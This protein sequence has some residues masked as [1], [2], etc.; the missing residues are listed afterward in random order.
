MDLL[1]AFSEAD[2]AGSAI[3]PNPVGAVDGVGVPILA[4]VAIE[5]A[6]ARVVDKLSVASNSLVDKLLLGGGAHLDCCLK[7]LSKG[8]CWLQG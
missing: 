8:K 6:R 7:L 3:D 1:A 5:A 4:L 2:I